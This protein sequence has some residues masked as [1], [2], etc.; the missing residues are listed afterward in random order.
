MD[1]V[2]HTVDFQVHKLWG[3]FNMLSWNY[4]EI[5]E[6]SYEQ[7]LNAQENLIPYPVD[8]DPSEHFKSEKRILLSSFQT[9][10]FSAMACEA[11]I[12]DLSAIHLGDDYTKKYIDKL[13]LVAKW[14]VVPS[15]ICG[16]SLEED[17]PAINALRILTRIRNSLVHHKSLPCNPIEEMNK[18]AKKQIDK[19]VNN[20]RVAFQAVVLLSLELNRVMKIKTGVLPFFEK[21]EKNIPEEIKSEKIRSEITRCREIDGKKKF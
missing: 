14:M 10:V 3:R 5:S 13:D 8:D 11:A 9:I 2:K 18:K 15:L 16:K 21:Y 7:F 12:Y 19:I 1:I 20:T 17:G 4:Y 6:S